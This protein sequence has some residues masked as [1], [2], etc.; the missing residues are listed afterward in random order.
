MEFCLQISRFGK[1]RREKDEAYL[2]QNK[3]AQ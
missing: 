2:N 3:L 1:I